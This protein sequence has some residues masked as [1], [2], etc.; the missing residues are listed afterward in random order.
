M[1]PKEFLIN[2]LS[3][4]SEK[5]SGINLKY[6]YDKDTDF[7]IIEVSPE[8]IRTGNTNYM[9]MEYQLWNDFYDMFPEED[10]LISDVD[11]INNMENIMYENES[12]SFN[13]KDYYS[14]NMGFS[15]NSS[16]DYTNNYNLILAA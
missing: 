14:I 8:S 15:F 12:T 7:H 3:L 4:I 9:E 10:L 5:I 1:T 2:K 16:E 6:A 13:E 11:N